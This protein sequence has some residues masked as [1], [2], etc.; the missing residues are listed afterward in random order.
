VAAGRRAT[1]S[2]ASTEVEALAAPVRAELVGQLVRWFA[3]EARDLPWRRTRDP[4]KIWLSEVMLQQTRVDTV[5]PY[6]ER[7]LADYPTVRALAAAP[8][9]EVLRRWSGLGY[10]RRA[11]QLHVAAREI[12]D[13]YGGRFPSTASELVKLQGVGA[14]TAGAVA[15]IAF[16]E[17]TPLVDGN[18]IRVLSR[19]FGLSEDMRQPRTQARVWALAR[20]LVPSDRPSDFNQGLMELG[21][22]VCTPRA[23]SCVRCPLRSVCV[24]HREDRAES[25][26]ILGA[27][28]PPKSE[29]LVATVITEG[30]RVMLGRRAASGLYA[31][32]WEPPVAADLEGARRE[33]ES[34]GARG[35]DVLV[36]VGEVRHVL[37][38]RR[39]AIEVWR[40]DVDTAGDAVQ[41]KTTRRKAASASAQSS[42]YDEVALRRPGEVPLSTLAK[43]L[44]RAAGVALAAALV[45]NPTRARADDEAPEPEPPS[46]DVSD[47]DVAWLQRLSEPRGSSFRLLL[48]ATG[49]RGVRFNNPFRLATQLGASP[50]G[51]SLTAPYVDAG[52][53]LGF[54]NPFGFQHGPVVHASFAT[55]GVA[56]PALSAGYALMRRTPV[57]LGLARAG[58]CLLAA[59]DANVGGEVALGGAVFATG[60]LGVTAEVV[61]NLFYGAGTYDKAYTLF[62]VVSVQAGLLVDLEVLP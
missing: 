9:E 45:L 51:P 38:H 59:P 26:P 43:K 11:R 33:L 1:E 28:K 62:P 46:A 42:P 60:A 61:G 37:S 30:G 24:A 16:G 6:Y 4:Y 35:V 40:G 14:Y 2:A 55:E 44:L 5:I 3:R 54:G 32:M 49:G 31:G 25:L 13:A 7:F 10:Y 17:A 50:E 15:S 21:S 36:R 34:R 19:V 39:L 22:Q 27:K 48:S 56:Q 58:A 29:A 20:A 41:P 23:P 57:I 8:L 12:V 52:F 47:A 53:A 18:V